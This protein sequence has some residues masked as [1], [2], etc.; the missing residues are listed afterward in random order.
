GG[1]RRWLPAVISAASRAGPASTLAAAEAGDRRPTLAA[2]TETLRDLVELAIVVDEN[3]D[4]NCYVLRR[5]DTDEV[6]V[7]DPGLQHPRTLQLLDKHG[8][9]CTRILLTHGH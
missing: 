2:M 6:L 7:V 5:R 4:Q 1:L 9:R 8:L 3:F